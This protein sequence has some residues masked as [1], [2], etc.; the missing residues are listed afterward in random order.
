MFNDLTQPN[1][2][3]QAGNSP[4]PPVDDIF[5][6]T[7]KAAEANKF[8]GYYA[9]TGAT[10]VPTEVEAQKVGL[11]SSTPL[12]V[13]AKGKILKIILIALLVILLISLGYLVYAKFL[14][15]QVTEEEIEQIDSVA[16]KTVEVVTPTPTTTEPEEIVPVSE[17]IIVS[18]ST[19]LTT[20]T[21]PVSNLVDT[22]GDGLTDEEEGILGT[23]INL[24]DTDDDGL[25]DYDEVK[26]YNIN[27][28]KIDSDGD[29]LSDYEEVKIY[30]TDPLKSDT[31]GDGYTD[32]SEVK[33]GYNPLG[34][35]KLTD[36]K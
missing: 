36:V 18:T 7:D 14:S 13:S 33:S 22:D 20:T 3:G 2:P 30:Q 26:I 16:T 21:P 11:S 25:S 4:V 27:A 9:N 12:P 31:D 15:G 6:D 17:E 34:E 29:A 24:K 1:Q 19:P 23:D 8:S 10:S 35:G 5:A 32:G 28:N